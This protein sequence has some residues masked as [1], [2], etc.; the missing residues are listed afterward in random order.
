MKFQGKYCL[1][2]EPPSYT[3]RLNP[4]EER[5][6]G[7]TIDDFSNRSKETVNLYLP[8]IKQET[9]PFNKTMRKERLH[10]LKNKYGKLLNLEENDEREP[11]TTICQHSTRKRNF[12]LLLANHSKSKERLHQLE[13]IT[14][15]KEKLTQTR[16]T[17]EA[18]S[19]SMGLCVP[20][21]DD[22][23]ENFFPEKDLPSNPAMVDTKK[24][25]KK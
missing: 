20:E 23:C 5:K 4:S 11:S 8:K 10:S 9:M 22:K 21:E 2:K 12:S 25:K 14:K 6:F 15:I 18:R 24:K 16:I 19:L 3:E 13:D 1:S 17:I 7:L